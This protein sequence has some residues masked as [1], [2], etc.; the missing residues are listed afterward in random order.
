[1]GGA[2]AALG[3]TVHAGVS[4]AAPAPL[5]AGVAALDGGRVLLGELPL[6]LSDG[7]VLQPQVTIFATGATAA[8]DALRGGRLAAALD[9][10][11]RLRVLPT[12]QVE[13]FPEVFA[14]GDICATDETKLGYHAGAQA[15]IVARNVALLAAVRAGAGAPPAPLATYK[16]AGHKTLFLTVGRRHAFGVLGGM[17]LPGFMVKAIKGDLLVGKFTKEMGYEK[18]GVFPGAAPMAA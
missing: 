10:A 16:P 15:P 8:A 4:A 12:M 9:G 3:V 17:A 14:L 18:P 11:G 13:G 2:L 7:S 6:A 1:M 5:P